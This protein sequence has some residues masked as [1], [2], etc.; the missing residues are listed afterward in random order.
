MRSQS[1]SDDQGLKSHSSVNMAK[2]SRCQGYQRSRS[3]NA[4]EPFPDGGDFFLSSS[5]SCAR[6]FS[7]HRFSRDS[8]GYGTEV[9]SNSQC[10]TFTGESLAD[11][12]PL[13]SPSNPWQRSSLLRGDDVSATY[14]NPADFFGDLSGSLYEGVLQV[15][16][17]NPPPQPKTRAFPR[18]NPSCIGPPH[19][20]VSRKISP[21]CQQVPNVPSTLDVNNGL[22]QLSQSCLGDMLDRK[23]GL[24]HD[25]S[26]SDTSHSSFG[27]GCLQQDR[28]DS[29]FS[30]GLSVVGRQDP[31]SDSLPSQ[32]SLS[33]KS[34]AAF[35]VLGSKSSA[36]YCKERHGCAK[37]SPQSSLSSHS[38]PCH[39]TNVDSNCHRHMRLA[40]EWIPSTPTRTRR[41]SEPDY[42]NLPTVAQ[43]ATA[44]SARQQL[45]NALS[46]SD[47][48]RT[49]TVDDGI[50]TSFSSPSSSSPAEFSKKEYEPRFGRSVLTQNSEGFV[51]QDSETS[52]VFSSPFFEPW[53][54]VDS[55]FEVQQ[56]GGFETGMKAIGKSKSLDVDDR[57][58]PPLLLFS[59]PHWDEELNGDPT[60]SNGL[61]QVS[62]IKM[63][64]E[65]I[66]FLN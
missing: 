53:Q 9:D 4:I 18:T 24:H 25:Q 63:Q 44:N 17:F 43:L 22:S 39:T 66:S 12:V 23:R 29:H 49:A 21:E 57:L 16:S 50:G 56:P 30:Q 38:S 1:N 34:D 59:F 51:D 54:S 11:D 60:R 41:N 36:K 7:P 26:D 5:A 64:G 48:L 42:A 10:T 65:I 31:R 46:L 13:E 61:N 19:R 33:G 55:A 35:S 62:R 37:V 45:G 32:G 8:P 58:V 14:D 27:I 52:S 28:K 40:S 20:D 3:P 6:Q 2:A 47:K 15:T